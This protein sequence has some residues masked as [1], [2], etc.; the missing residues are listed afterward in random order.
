LKFILPKERTL[1]IRFHNDPGAYVA[2]Y[3]RTEIALDLI[4]KNN[5]LRLGPFSATNDPRETKTWGFA[6]GASRERPSADVEALAN[7]NADFDRILKHGCKILCVSEDA[8]NT[9]KQN[10]AGRCFGKVRMWAQYT[11]NHTGVC[12]IFDKEALDQTLKSTLRSRGMLMSGPVKY[13]D[14][15][16][17]IGSTDWIA[18]MDAFMLSA[19]DIA[20]RGLEN[21]LRSA[22]NKHI[23]TFFFQKSKDWES[24]T[25]YRWILLGEMDE[26]E[27]VPLD[28][29]LRA[30]LLG[31]DFPQHRLAEVHSYCRQ[32]Q[33]HLSRIVWINGMPGV[34]WLAPDE[35]SAAEFQ[36]IRSMFGLNPN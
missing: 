8:A 19:N 34:H 28:D 5:S 35:L 6:I 2:H 21:V 32:Y 13:R 22:R 3:T 18:H 9:W 27:F 10:V 24:E 33:A 14:F 17:D 23:Q 29:S 20:S 16:D 11:D 31:I 36:R 7:R 25:E 12:L 26:P 30:I 15:W 4:L 1:N